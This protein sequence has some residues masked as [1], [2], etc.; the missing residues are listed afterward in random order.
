MGRRR[1]S[2]RLQVPAFQVLGALQV[3]WGCRLALLWWVVCFA[4]V[5][6]VS[7]TPRT[8]ALPLPVCSDRPGPLQLAQ[9]WA[10]GVGG[11]GCQERGL[12]ANPTPFTLCLPRPQA[13]RNNSLNAP[14]TPGAPLPP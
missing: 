14:G 11:A 9:R 2:L 12:L 4:V 7:T 6:C 10:A 5:W 8:I 13:A 3:N 1:G